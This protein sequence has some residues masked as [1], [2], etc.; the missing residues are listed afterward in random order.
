MLGNLMK[1]LKALAKLRKLG[2]AWEATEE[3]FTDAQ[4][5]MSKYDDLDD[6]LKDLLVKI[7]IAKGR[8]GEV[9]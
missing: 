5:L 9:F 4:A 8:W 1:G 6:D 7:K 3:V 2:S